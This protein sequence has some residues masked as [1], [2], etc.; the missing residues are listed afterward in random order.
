M[1]HA[2]IGK[3]G[4]QYCKDVSLPPNLTL[5][6]SAISFKIPGGFLF[7]Y[8]FFNEP[9]KLISS[10]SIEVQKTKHSQT[11]LKKTM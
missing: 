9:E 7:V 10:I 5:K 2:W 1:Q 11:L 6:F 8:L 3:L 4:S